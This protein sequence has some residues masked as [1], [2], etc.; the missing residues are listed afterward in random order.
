MYIFVQETCTRNSQT[1]IV[2]CMAGLQSI[3]HQA[4]K[5]FN[6][7]LLGA[8]VSKAGV[9]RPVFIDS[10]TS[11]FTFSGHCDNNL[12]GFRYLKRY[13]PEDLVRGAISVTIVVILI[14]P[15]LLRTS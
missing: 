3:Y 6:T 12:F 9:V 4:H 11:V 13:V 7:L 14:T 8:C 2:H 1:R 15:P 10:S 5:R